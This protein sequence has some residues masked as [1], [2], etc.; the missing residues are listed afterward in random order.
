MVLTELI[1]KRQIQ[2]KLLYA[3]W[4]CIISPCYNCSLSHQSIQLLDS[5]KSLNSLLHSRNWAWP[6]W[7]LLCG[8]SSSWLPG[9]S[10]VG[11]DIW[12]GGQRPASGS[13]GWPRPATPGALSILS[14]QDCSI[15]RQVLTYSRCWVKLC[16]LCALHTDAAKFRKTL[17]MSA[18]PLTSY[19]VWGHFGQ[20]LR[21]S[22]C[23]WLD[24][25]QAAPTPDWN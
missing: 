11:A 18:L 17:G 16:L 4:H 12:P 9:D 14:I 1:I 19:T 2:L 7:V 6:F 8:G 23:Q 25:W 5:L 21:A 13:R 10:V 24:P 3:N 15:A 22:V 20:T